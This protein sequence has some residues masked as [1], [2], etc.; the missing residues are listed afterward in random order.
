MNEPSREQLLGYL[1]GALDRS[2]QEQ[3]ETD[4]D[5][6]LE[7]RAELDRLSARVRQM[8][9]G[10]EPR[11][12][13]P[14]V[15]LAERTCRFVARQTEPLVTRA[16][17][18]SSYDG[19]A[20]QRRMTWYDMITAAAVLII[21]V[22]LFFPAVSHSRFQARI[23]SCQNNLRQIGQAMHGFS[24]AQPDGRFPA[25][26]ASGK[27]AAAG[28]VASHL[29]AH[30][31]TDSP[32]FLC[33]GSPQRRRAGEFRVA[34]PD[35]V[36][37]AEGPELAAMQRAMGGDYGYNLGYVADG[38]LQPPQNSRRGQYVL[39]ADAPS[40]MQPNRVSSNH[41]GRGQNMLYEDG[42]VQFLPQISSS[43]LLDDPYHNREGW[44]SAGL[45][46]DDAVLG[47]SA[48]HPLPITLTN[49]PSR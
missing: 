36:D 6:D 16:A 18:L 33:S 27:R 2:D 21:G 37:A 1:L 25:P 3:V 29:V 39:V 24:E 13:E 15:G 26:E 31:L 49:H 42:H 38:Q 19:A 48:D 30:R 11:H 9:L 34:L 12:F 28:M 43:Q 8:G 4:L 10:E 20:Q 44:V 23:A 17:A 41:G 35:A 7:L 14:P 32:N 5:H 45:D 47:A 46:R 22:S 40:D